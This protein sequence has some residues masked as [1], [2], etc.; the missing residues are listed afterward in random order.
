MTRTAMTE[1]LLMVGGM[2]LALAVFGW[3]V[4]HAITGAA[5]LIPGDDV[6][7]F[8]SDCLALALG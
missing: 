3:Y 7:R 6:C 8:G 4:V 1:D 2:F 5:A